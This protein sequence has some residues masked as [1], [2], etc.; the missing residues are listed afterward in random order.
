[1][2]INGKRILGYIGIFVI[3]LMILW[4]LLIGAA[5]ISNNQIKQNMQES[6]LSYG[7]AEAFAF[8]DGRKLNGV[9]DNYADSIWLNVAWYMGKGNPIKSSLDTKY[10]DGEDGGENIGLF[11]AVAD[12][13]VEANTEYTRYWH[14]IAGVLRFMHLFMDVNGIKI[15]GMCLVFVLAI[16]VAV[17]LIRAKKLPLAIGFGLALCA[18]ETWK[19]GL[20]LEYQPAFILCFLMCILY[21]LSEKKGDYWIIGV[22]VASGVMTAFFDFLTTETMVILMP[23]ILVVIVRSMDGRLENLKKSLMWLIHCGVAW[24]LSYGCTFLVKWTMATLVTGENCFASALHSVEE[25]VAGSVEEIIPGGVIGQSIYAVVSNV[26]V[27]FGAEERVDWALAIIG[28]LLFVGMILTVL[29]LFP[30]K[31]RDKT[32]TV[33]LVVLGSVVFLR[34]LVLGNQAYLHSFFTYRALVSVIFA[35]FGIVIVNCR[36]PIPGKLSKKQTKKDRKR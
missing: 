34:Y 3:T 4:L 15:T 9:A 24:V 17:L 2:R 18:V 23:L 12:E 16:I 19:T 28:T 8:C 1:M 32:A 27:L 7:Q 35:A 5:M 21:L 30:K 10:F 33:L 14:G 11:M 31:E 22:S 26:S 20:C 13:N 36:L 25:R 29:Y 6:A